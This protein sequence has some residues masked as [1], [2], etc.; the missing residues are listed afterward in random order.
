MKYA[1]VSDVHANLDALEAVLEDAG[2]VPLLCLRDIVGCGAQPN[3]CVEIIRSRA[4]HTVMGN[5]DLAFAVRTGLETMNTDLAS[6]CFGRTGSPCDA[7]IEFLLA[8]P[9]VVTTST[10]LC[11]IRPTDRRLFGTCATYATPKTR[12]QPPATASSS[13][14]IRTFRAYS[15]VRQTNT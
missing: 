3:E 4:L 12:S 15:Y 11:T 1:I 6:R 9:F 10:L 5:H 8:L 14:V 13:S 7:N 2:D